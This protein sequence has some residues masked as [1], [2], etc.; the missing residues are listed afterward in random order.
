MTTAANSTDSSIVDDL[1]Q[2]VEDLR[3]IVE[4][5]AER[6]DELEMELAEHKDYTGREVADIRGR[7]SDVEDDVETLENQQ[8]KADSTNKALGDEA[9]KG[10]TKADQTPLERICTLPEHITDRELTINQKRAR[11]IAKDI[12]D[13]AEKAPAG[14]VIDSR[15]VKRVITAKERTRPHTQTVVRVM[16]F[17][18][19]L[20]KDDIKLKK[21]RGK[22]LIVVNPE[23]A[24]RYTANHRSGDM[25]SGPT[26]PEGVIS[27]E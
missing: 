14:F 2:S 13:Y 26:H 27:S 18:D 16:D 25:S 24:T 10:G 23:A 4:R 9:N 15:A 8:I 17:L 5:Q 11:F 6:I 22:K 19:D 20:G 12:H 1:I 7:I 3:E 21:H